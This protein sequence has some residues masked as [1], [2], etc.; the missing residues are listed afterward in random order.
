MTGSRLL[1]SDCV[2]SDSDP[3]GS[4]PGDNTAART[5][6]GTEHVRHTGAN[7]G[8]QLSLRFSSQFSP[9]WIATFLA[10][11]T[12][13]AACGA[14]IVLAQADTE[15]KETKP[16]APSKDA[17]KDKK[18][19]RPAAADR[20]PAATETKPS[21]P[22]DSGQGNDKPVEK[23]ADKPSDPDAPP[24]EIGADSEDLPLI[25]EMGTPALEELLKGPPRDWLVLRSR[26]VLQVEPVEP[27]PNL[28]SFYEERAKAALKQADTSGNSAEA[29]LKRK[30]LHYLP[31]VIVGEDDDDYR[32]HYK[33]LLDVVYWDDLLLRRV[34]KLL[35]DQQIPEALALWMVARDRNDQWPGLQDRYRRLLFVDGDVKAREGQLEPALAVW[36]ELHGVAANYPQLDLR[37]GEVADRLIQGALERQDN[38]RARFYLGRLKARYPAHPVASNWTGRFTDDAA[39][40]VRESQNETVVNIALD[41]MERATRIWPATP[42][43]FGPYQ[44]AH[45]GWTRITVGVAEPTRQR[46]SPWPILDQ[47]L[48]S[49]LMETPWFQP[50][51]RL[52]GTIRFESR[53]FREWEPTDLG[54]S[55]TFTLRNENGVTAGWSAR[56]LAEAVTPGS[57][58][59]SVRLA[60]TLGR[61]EVLSPETFKA[62]LVT[63]PLRPEALLATLPSPGSENRSAS[64]R[65][66]PPFRMAESTPLASQPGVS[67]T[68]FQRFRRDWTPTGSGSHAPHEVIVREFESSDL[69]IQALFRGELTMLSRVPLKTIRELQKRNEYVTLPYG[70]PETHLLQFSPTSPKVASRAVRRAMMFGLNRSRIMGEAFS[71]AGDVNL[72]RLTPTIVPSTSYAFDNGMPTAPYDPTVALSLLSAVKKDN[73]GKLPEITLWHP[74]GAE[75]AEA[76]RRLAAAWNLLGLKTTVVSEASAPTPGDADVL[77]RTVAMAEPLV[78]MWPFLAL[79]TSPTMESLDRFPVWLR[80]SLLELDTV[81]DVATATRLLARLQRQ[82]WAEVVVIPLWETQPHFVARKQVRN[83]PN[84]PMTL[85]QGIDRWQVDAWYP[86]D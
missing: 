9:L 7:A 34:D 79:T 31:I 64:T 18:E 16:A 20:K 68:S 6:P 26:R 10:V 33:H 35:D 12:A 32:I 27:R 81:G 23:P 56:R 63:V 65:S 55:L 72:A 43:L 52:E 57:A 45:L 5:K 48:S 80:R 66:W 2:F 67:G 37:Y 19:K 22:A 15:P 86:P 40:L 71:V 54:R 42:N 61:M 60:G 17:T 69:A 38:R 41:R 78:E 58:S 1:F 25:D 59:Y 82:L 51:S 47:G 39:R 85:F 73:D 13:W 24:S 28:I 53:W 84:G 83:L 8:R 11:L 75:I 21:K 14:A 29:Q 30:K 50:G 36:D 77:Y 46:S 4:R 62:G 49:Q 74:R 3:S 70:L 44:K 76:A